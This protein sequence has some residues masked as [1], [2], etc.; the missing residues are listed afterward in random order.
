MKCLWYEHVHQESAKSCTRKQENF[1]K[2]LRRHVSEK[3]RDMFSRKT[4][5]KKKKRHENVA[6][7]KLSENS[8]RKYCARKTARKSVRKYARKYFRVKL[9]SFACSFYTYAYENIFR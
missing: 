9:Y 3:L 2:I 4:V 1:T 6:R 8:L 7:E 5:R